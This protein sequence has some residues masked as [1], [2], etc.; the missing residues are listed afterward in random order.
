MGARHKKSNEIAIFW[1][2]IVNKLV[3]YI[4]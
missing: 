1:N 2:E 4:M 3:T